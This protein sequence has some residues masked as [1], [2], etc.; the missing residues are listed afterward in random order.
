MSNKAILLPLILILFTIFILIYPKSE[1][2]LSPSIKKNLPQISEWQSRKKQATAKEIQALSP[3]TEFLKA[4]FTNGKQIIDVSI[5]FSGKDLNN[6]I[7]RPERCL[8]AQGHINLK[9]KSQK[10]QISPKISLPINRITSEKRIY[11]AYKIPYQIKMITYY[12]FIG[13]QNFC[14]SHLKRTLIDIQDK[15]L[16]GKAQRWAYVSLS[17]PYEDIPWLNI[18]MPKEESV[19]LLQSFTQKLIKQSVHL[20]E[21]KNLP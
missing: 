5:V 8:P 19:K 13:H 18:Y 15:L 16:K 2:L 1:K 14:N 20:E 11:D 6:S 17:I 12:F 10:I 4:Q 3:D 21:I 9:T 7:H